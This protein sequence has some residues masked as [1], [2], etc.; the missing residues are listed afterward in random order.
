[1]STSASHKSKTAIILTSVRDDKRNSEAKEQAFD[2][3]SEKVTEYACF[4]GAFFMLKSEEQR[5]N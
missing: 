2:K 4:V 3:L 1:M 5:E